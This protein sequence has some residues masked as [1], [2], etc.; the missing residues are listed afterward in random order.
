MPE[1]T[2]KP[3]AE[4]IRS[5]IQK[6]IDG[7]RQASKEHATFAESKVMDEMPGMTDRQEGRSLQLLDCADELA[8]VLKGD[9]PDD[10]QYGIGVDVIERDE[11]EAEAGAA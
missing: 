11:R 4:V 3:N 8:D 5:N 10:W 1:N 6:L 2:D 7:W 9:D